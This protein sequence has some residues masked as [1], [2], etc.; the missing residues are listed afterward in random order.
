MF[1]Y[2]TRNLTCEIMFLFTTNDISNIYVNAHK[3]FD[4]ILY[5]NKGINLKL[6]IVFETFEF[7]ILVSW[8]KSQFFI[9]NKKEKMEMQNKIQK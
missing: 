6:Q 8:S 7:E 2:F 9:Q 3:H 1:K 5:C 4:S